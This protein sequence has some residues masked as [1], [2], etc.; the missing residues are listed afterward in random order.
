M[1]QLYNPSATASAGG[2]TVLAQNNVLANLTAANLDIPFTIAAGALAANDALIVDICFGAPLFFQCAFDIRLISATKGTLFQV[3]SSYNGGAGASSARSILSLYVDPN[4]P[5]IRS[6]FAMIGPGS[7]G[8]VTAA[9]NNL[10]IPAV[11]I[12][13]DW[14]I[15][16]NFT[17]R[18]VELNNDT[19]KY[20]WFRASSM[21]LS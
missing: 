10:A 20:E 15:A 5:S 19:A 18:M 14:T 1:G 6:Y 7:P 17:L 2:N 8:A 12:G 9:V 11:A 3:L 21:K 4:F 13:L 16:Q